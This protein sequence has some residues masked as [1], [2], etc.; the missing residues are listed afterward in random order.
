MTV[1]IK[2]LPKRLTAAWQL[3][4]LDYPCFT[5]SQS[6]TGNA[7]IESETQFPTGGRASNQAFPVG[8]WERD[9]RDTR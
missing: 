2:L 1:T 4:H 7:F 3:H 8:D 9:T 5:R 6:P